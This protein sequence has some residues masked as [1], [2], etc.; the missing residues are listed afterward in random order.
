M[1]ARAPRRVPSYRLHKRSGQAVVTLDGRDFYLGPFGSVASRAEYD[2][3]VAEW[4]ANGRRLPAAGDAA[5]PADFTVSELLVAYLEHADTYYR[6]KDGTPTTEPASIRQTIPPLRRLYGATPARDFGPLALKAVRRAM[7]D[8]DLCRNE[9]NKRVGR[10]VRIFKWAVENE[11]VPAAVYHGLKA[12]AGLRAGRSEARETA[13]V[14]PV[15]EAFVQAVRPLVAR[16]V[17]AMIHLQLLTGMRP[18]EVCQMRTCDLDTSGAVWVYTPVCHKTQHHGKE[19]PIYLGPRAQDILRPWL[20][21]DTT[22]HL[23]S[24]AEAMDER[25]AARRAAR[26]TKVQPSQRARRR[27][28]RPRRAPGSC[29]TT[30][31]YHHAIRA[32]C[33]RAGIDPPWHPHQ[34]RHNAATA[35]RR[36]FGLDVARTVLGHSSPAVTQVYAE[37]DRAKAADAMARVG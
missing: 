13:P 21:L 33:K 4:M 2:R 5:A 35:L 11:L 12:V 32:A 15:P 9:V 14:R 29:Y 18:G 20:R 30:K 36:E 24:P 22:A 17:R 31:A 10:V 1:A 37:A 6:R 8:D 27:K 3:L 34:L 16:Q 7:I 19:R 25:R 23:F 26:K 28:A